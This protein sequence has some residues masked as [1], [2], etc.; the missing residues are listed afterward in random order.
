MKDEHSQLRITLWPTTPIPERPVW[1]HTYRLEGTRWLRWTGRVAGM[2]PPEVVLRDLPRLD[3]DDADA[4]LAF[5][6]CYGWQPMP[7]ASAT[8]LRLR[9]IGD[10]PLTSGDE[11]LDDLVF[12][13]RNVKACVGLWLAYLRG[14][15]IGNAWSSSLGT[16]G[17]W[18]EPFA[19]ELF[20]FTV[21]AGLAELHPFVEIVPPRAWQE[22]DGRLLPNPGVSLFAALIG[23]LFNVMTE[24][25]PI[26][27]CANETCERSF[28]RQQGRARKGVHRTEGVRFCS[29]QCAKAQTQREYRRRNRK[30]SQ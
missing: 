12:I 10:A 17:Q 25:L 14:D 16:G 18:D 19:W 3:C 15:D 29:A 24:G 13:M 9:P 27:T 4:V 6:N 8:G 28:V 23:Q 1:G 7:V 2:L 26:L 20:R 22:Q 30:D 21:H 5:V 11:S